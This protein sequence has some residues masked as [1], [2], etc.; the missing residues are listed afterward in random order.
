MEISDR[1]RIRIRINVHGFLANRI[2]TPC[3]RSKQFKPYIRHA[4]YGPYLQVV[5][6]LIPSS[7][8]CSFWSIFFS[9]VSSYSALPLLPFSIDACV[10]Q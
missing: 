1:I 9:C 6:G 7:I 3:V 10:L 4:V 8:L 5:H 2:Y